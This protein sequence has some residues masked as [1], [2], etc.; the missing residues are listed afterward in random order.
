MEYTQG[1][2]SHP[3]TAFGPP[4]PVGVVGF[5]EPAEFWFREWGGES[6]E[7]WRGFMPDGFEIAGALEVSGV[8]L[9]KLCRDASYIIEPLN[10]TP[11]ADIE[12]A[13]RSE[14]GELGTLLSVHSDQRRVTI[15]VTDPEKSGA[16][17]MVKSL[18]AASMVSG[19]RDLAIGRLSVGCWDEGKAK[20]IP[21]S[22][23]ILR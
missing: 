22:E 19:W 14:F 8:S 1:F 7:K 6:L 18:V 3:R 13:M 17:R 10:G 2:S 15:S 4:L 23:E 21:L 12:L 16:S 9:A 5:S 11:C 20:V